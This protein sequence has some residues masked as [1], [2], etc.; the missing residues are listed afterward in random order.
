[1]ATKRNVGRLPPVPSCGN[2]SGVGRTL[3]S[4]A[5]IV[6]SDAPRPGRSRGAHQPPSLISSSAARVEWDASAAA[7]RAGRVAADLSV[8]AFS[9]DLDFLPATGATGAIG[10]TGA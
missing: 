7:E 10:A 1:M 5:K 3:T 2:L 9:T 4:D 8:T 6:E